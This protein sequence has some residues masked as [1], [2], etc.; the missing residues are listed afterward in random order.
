MKSREIFETHESELGINFLEIILPVPPF[1]EAKFS[2]IYGDDSDFGLM[3]NLNEHWDALW[4]K[5]RDQLQEGIAG[6]GSGQDLHSKFEVS[7][8]PNEDDPDVFMSEESDYMISFHLKPETP[9][10][11]AF[12]KGD[13]VVHFQP[14][15]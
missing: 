13:Q 3:L 2:T 14:V 1:G 8:N 11:D 12:I 4:P 9:F 7:V 15:F 6:Y 10:W 5:L